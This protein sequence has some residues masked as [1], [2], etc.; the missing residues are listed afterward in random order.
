MINHRKKAAAALCA[1]GLIAVACGSDSKDSESTSAATSPPAATSG[2]T[3]PAATTGGTSG[4]GTN[5]YGATLKDG[6][7]GEK[8]TPDADILAKGLGGAG[9]LPEEERARNVALATIARAS[10]PV[11]ED[12]ALKCWKDNGCDT[13]TGGKLKVGLADGF[14][15]N[16]ARQTFK[17][18]FIL[19]ALTYPEIGHIGYT[20]ANLDTQKAI[21]DVRSFAAQGY[22]VILSFPDAGEALVPAY[23]AATD[24]GAQ[25]VTWSS[26]KVGTPGK[27]YLTY[28]G[29]DIC[30]L[31]H[32]WG[33][34]FAKSLPDGGDIAMILGAPGNPIDPVHEKCLQEKLPANIKIVAKQGTAWSR[35]AYLEA[36]SAILAEHPDLKGIVGSYGDAF[37]GAMRAFDAAGISMKGLVT[38]HQSDDNPFL[39]A[40]KDAGGIMDSYTYVSLLLEGRAGMTAAM[41][42]IAGYDVPPQIIFGV[43]LKKVTADSCRTDIPPDGSPSSLVPP[44]LQKKMFP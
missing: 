32:A 35:D 28:S 22:N 24:Q 12:L 8:Y 37:V 5:E 40:W 31:G 7:F 1:L 18:E 20:D 38:M 10:I 36:T 2:D 9:S 25:V 41:M 13:G 33:E 34:Q 15:G 19:Q 39:C 29:S 44:E 17:M 3:T 14:G 43:Q 6:D 16:I 11:D 21:S 30:S 27:D 23:K 26:G 42:K 4:G